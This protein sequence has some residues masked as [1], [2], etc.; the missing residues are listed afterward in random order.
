MSAGTS[1]E[2]VVSGM[3]AEIKNTFSGKNPY[4]MLTSYTFVDFIKFNE[5]RLANTFYKVVKSIPST[6]NCPDYRALISD[7]YARTLDREF[8]QLKDTKS[9][10]YDLLYNNALRT[11]IKSM[12]TELFQRLRPNGKG[13]TVPKPIILKN[14]LTPGENKIDIDMYFDYLLGV[15]AYYDAKTEEYVVSFGVVPFGVVQN[16]IPK[17]SAND[18]VKVRIPNDSWSFISKTYRIKNAKT[19]EQ[20]ERKNNI[21]NTGLDNIYFELQRA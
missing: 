3:E 18:Q 17:E 16:F 5:E 19:A 13:L 2:K 12:Q 21:L 4:K 11:S 10:G 14:K 15:S 8:Y 20:E 9:I 1:F 6:M 7:A